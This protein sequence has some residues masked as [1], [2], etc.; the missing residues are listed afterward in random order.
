[1]LDLTSIFVAAIMMISSGQDVKQNVTAQL[2]SPKPQ[3]VQVNPTELNCLAKTIYYEAGSEPSVGKYAVGFATLNRTRIKG[4]PNT[5]C[6]VVRQQTPD[7]MGKLHCQFSWY[8]VNGESRLQST[9]SNATYETALT[10]AKRILSKKVDNWMP[11][12]VSFHSTKVDP[13]WQ[14]MGKLSQSAIYGNHIF[15]EIK[16]S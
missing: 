1:M 14:H 10:V 6:K 8:C 15:Y 5:I 7:K 16:E 9:P 3:V 13:H 11:R 4:Y 2:F 12:T